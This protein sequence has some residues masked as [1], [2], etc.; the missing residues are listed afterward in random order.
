MQ[1]CE[2][3]NNLWDQAL[4]A[5]KNILELDL[6]VFYIVEGDKLV[7]KAVSREAYPEG[8]KEHGIDEGVAGKTM[9]EGKTIHGKDIRDWEEAEPTRNDL[10]SFVSIPIGDIGVLQAFS[11]RR[12]TFDKQD[13]NLAEILAGHLREEVARIRLE[14]KL[15]QQ[16]IRDPLTGLFNRRY[17]NQSLEKEIERANRY[18]HPL[19]FLMLDINRFKEINDRYSHLRGDKVL[20]A[21]ANLLQENVRDADTVV[22]YGGDE[23]LIILPETDG[24]TEEIKGRIRKELNK[25]NQK[26]DILDFP[27]TLGIGSSYWD[28]GSDMTVEEVLKEADRRMYEDKNNR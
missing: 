14:E 24:E 27:L 11:T 12:G 2:K 6:C 7:P 16:A 1:R 3:E 18:N 20:K 15:R 17:F 23:F 9:R 28:P 4:Q 26:Q 19:G 8:I 10:R 21:V 13:V 25:W 5:A 22:R